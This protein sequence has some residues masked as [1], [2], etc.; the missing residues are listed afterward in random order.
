MDSD[1]MS[2]II[3]GF[4]NV[5]ITIAD[6]KIKTTIRIGTNPGFVLNRG[7]LAAKIGKRD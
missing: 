5:N 3:D 4:I 1:G 2:A 6:F 7:A